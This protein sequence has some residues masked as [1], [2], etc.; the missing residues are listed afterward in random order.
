[1]ANPGTRL[2]RKIASE[3]LT[4]FTPTIRPFESM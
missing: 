4:I 1:M 3:T 2:C